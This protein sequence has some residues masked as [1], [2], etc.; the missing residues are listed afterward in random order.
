MMSI[1][2]DQVDF[3]ENVGFAEK[4]VFDGTSELPITVVRY[5]AVRAVKE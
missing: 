2:S 1:D 3:S 4:S 5:P